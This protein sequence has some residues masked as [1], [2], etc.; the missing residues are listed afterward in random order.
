MNTIIV[1]RRPNDHHKGPKTVAT[2]E[3]GKPVPAG[4][5]IGKGSII[6]VEQTANLPRPIKPAT[7]EPTKVYKLILKKLNKRTC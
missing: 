2:W 6:T 1:V 7:K 4:I 3:Y 5:I